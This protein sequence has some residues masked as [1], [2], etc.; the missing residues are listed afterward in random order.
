MLCYLSQLALLRNFQIFN[1]QYFQVFLY[2]FQ[3]MVIHK[4]LT[5]NFLF[6]NM[7]NLTFG[8]VEHH[9]PLFRS[10]VTLNR[11][12]LSVSRFWSS[13]ILLNIF[14]SPANFKIQLVILQSRLLMQIKNRSCPNTEPWETAFNTGTKSD[15]VPLMLTRCFLLFKHSPCTVLPC[16]STGFQFRH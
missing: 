15:K 1:D 7:H 10:I 11:F 14:V 8:S 9:L 3:L 16:Q 13:V 4:I 12:C 6:T 2:F 5:L